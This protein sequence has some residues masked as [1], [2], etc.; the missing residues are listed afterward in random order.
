MGEP[1]ILEALEIAQ[2]LARFALAHVAQQKGRGGAPRAITLRNWVANMQTLWAQHFGERFT[3]SEENGGS[4]ALL[5]C[6]DVMTPLDP[7]VKPA[8]IGTAMRT[9]IGRFNK[10]ERAA[11]SGTRE[12]VHR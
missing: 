8:A 10:G 6:L 2:N 12:N 9:M 4:R 1:E 7:K 3:Y 5:F 11:A